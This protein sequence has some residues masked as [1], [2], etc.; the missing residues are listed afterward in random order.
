MRNYCADPFNIDMT[1][2][3]LNNIGFHSKYYN[4]T[5]MKNI[6]EKEFK[7]SFNLNF[8]RNVSGAFVADEYYNIARR[9]YPFSDLRVGQLPHPIAIRITLRFPLPEPGAVI[10]DGRKVFNFFKF[11][12]GLELDQ[13]K[14][15]IFEYERNL[16]TEKTNVA[17]SV[18]YCNY[19]FLCDKDLYTTFKVKLLVDE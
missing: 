5:K 17:S 13:I 16:T 6:T 2:E 12:S 11:L 1:L 8:D 4:Q 3:I 14:N 7:E 10:I 19:I 9:Y 15:L 18:A